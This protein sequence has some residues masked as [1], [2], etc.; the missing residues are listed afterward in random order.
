M[1]FLRGLT[2]IS[3]IAVPWFLFMIATHG[4][5]YL[6][7]MIVNETKDRLIVENEGPAVLGFV[8][9]FLDHAVYYL[10]VLG[11]YFAPWSLF[12]IGAL[13]FA[14]RRSFGKEANRPLLFL[15]LWFLLVYCFF[16][17]IYFTINHYMLVLSTPFAIMIS[18]FCLKG[19]ER[20]HSNNDPWFILRK[21]YPSIV[22]LIGGM[23]YVFLAVFLAGYSMF[24]LPLITVFLMAVLVYLF[25]S[26][27]LLSAPLS[28]GILIIFV[29]AQ[30]SMMGRA[31]VTAHAALQKFA[32][33]I[34]HEMNNRGERVAIAAGSH[35]IHEKEFQVYFDQRVLKAAGSDDDYTQS[36]LEE[37]FNTDKIVYCLITEVDYKKFIENHYNPPIEILQEDYIVRRRMYIDRNFFVALL[38]LDQ[39]RVHDYIKEKL[40]LVKKE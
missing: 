11:N 1:R 21:V 32:E 20:G 4:M 14:A 34:H 3:V 6:D 37:L 40:V 28:L 36:R 26:K 10:S 12:L 22:F 9:T 31:G 15:L 13:P 2:V 29:F 30:S 18:A 19:L 5:S 35:D 7:Y 16:S 23:A 39:E 8:R 38:R 27:S 17:S 25:K 33:T 24:W